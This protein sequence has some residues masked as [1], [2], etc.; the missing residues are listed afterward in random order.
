MWRNE[1]VHVVRH[2]DNG[3]QCIVPY[4]FATVDCLCEEY[5]DFLAATMAGPEPGL[6]E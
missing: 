5:R 2:C 1:Q 4:L 3:S 6:I